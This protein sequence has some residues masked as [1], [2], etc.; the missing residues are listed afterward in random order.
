MSGAFPFR[1]VTGNAGKLS[2]ARRIVGPRLEAVTIDLPEIQSLS[3][4]RVLEAKA[5]AA[6]RAVRSPIVVEETGLELSALNGFPGPLVRWMLDAIGAEGIARCAL[7]LGNGHA[8][9]RCALLAYDGTHRLFAEGATTGSLV[10]PG[11]GAGGFGWDPVF[12]PD[13]ETRTYGEMADSEKDAIS[14]RGRAWRVLLEQIA[15]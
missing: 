1:F 5:E 13:D 11:R 12:V 14:H 3:L 7:D 2:E 15:A 4:E 8:V 6:W 10:L 9:A